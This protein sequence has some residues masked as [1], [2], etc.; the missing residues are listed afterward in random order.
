MQPPVGLYNVNYSQ[1]EKNTRI[2][3]FNRSVPHFNRDKY[4]CNES[5]HLYKDIPDSPLCQSKIK[6]LT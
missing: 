5:H 6:G 4:F 2:Y 1:V 3:N